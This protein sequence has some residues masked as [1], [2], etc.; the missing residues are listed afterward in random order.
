M[1]IRKL[2]RLILQIANPQISTKT[3]TSLSQT[4]LKVVF[5]KRFFIYVQIWVKAFNATFLGRKTCI[6]GL[7]EVLK[8]RK[9]QKD[10]VRISQIRAVSHL[11][12]V[13]KSNKLFKAAIIFGLAICRILFR[14]AH[15]WYLTILSLLYFKTWEIQIIANNKFFTKILIVFSK[16]SRDRGYTIGLMSYY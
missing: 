11:R 16:L 12:K 15:L 13:R 7:A 8:I 9:S 6:C 3:C 5:C 4:V 2:L 1:K 14:T 10:K